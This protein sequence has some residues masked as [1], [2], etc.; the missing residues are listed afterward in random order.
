[1]F[2]FSRTA[3]QFSK[4]VVLFLYCHQQRF[5]FQGSTSL[6]IFGIVSLFNFRHFQV[7]DFN[8]PQRSF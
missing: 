4:V 6:L 3:K 5:E 2:T 8:K 1:M 7:L